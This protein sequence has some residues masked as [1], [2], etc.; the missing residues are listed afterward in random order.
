MSIH[1]VGVCVGVCRC[2]LVGWLQVFPG[3]GVVAVGV[4]GGDSLMPELLHVR[5]H[6]VGRGGVGGGGRLGGLRRRVC[7]CVQPLHTSSLCFLP[8]G[9]SERAYAA[10]D[11]SLTLLM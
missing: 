1:G 10:S 11:C 9:K 8:G 3:H 7:V 5:Q 6:P 4:C 2:V